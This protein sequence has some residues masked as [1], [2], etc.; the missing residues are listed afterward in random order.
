MRGVDRFNKSCAA[1]SHICRRRSTCIV[2]NDQI[3]YDVIL[4]YCTET[5]R[6]CVNSGSI[7]FCPLPL[8]LMHLNQDFLYRK[9]MPPLLPYQKTQLSVDPFFTPYFCQASYYP[10]QS[11]V[12]FLSPS[13]T[14]SSV[15]LPR[16][17]TLIMA[18]G[19]S[20]RK[21]RH[22]ITVYNTFKAWS[23]SSRSATKNES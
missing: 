19:P 18:V 23:S 17:H 2:S 14:I 13:G 4:S 9:V 3:W 12:H 16:F 5:Y 20:I 22:M 10:F 15:V 21:N 6:H 7:Q 1:P 11:S 8:S